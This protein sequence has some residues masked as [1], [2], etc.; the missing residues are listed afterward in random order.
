LVLVFL[1]LV[2]QAT[3]WSLTYTGCWTSGLTVA[4][5]HR[6]LTGGYT[7]ALRLEQAPASTDPP[8]ALTW[9][10]CCREPNPKTSAATTDNPDEQPEEENCAN[11]RTLARAGAV[12]DRRLPDPDGRV[13]RARP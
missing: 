12:H 7:V 10:Q 11:T 4:E 8:P 3:G 5:P 1:V 2:D 13:R 9:E 6:D